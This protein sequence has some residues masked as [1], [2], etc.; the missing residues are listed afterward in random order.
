M[1]SKIKSLTQEFYTHYI[2]FAYL[3]IEKYGF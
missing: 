2:H 3:K 1:S